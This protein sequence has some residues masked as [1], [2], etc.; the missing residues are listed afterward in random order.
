MT[1]SELKYLIKI[2]EMYDGTAGIRLTAIAA[3]MNVTKVSVFKAAERLEQDGCIRRDEKNKVIVTQ[4]GR[5]QLAKYNMLIGWLGGHLE[6]NCKVPADI[7]RH[8]A[9]GAV[10][11]FSEE[12]IAALTEFITKQKEN[13]HDR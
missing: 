4:H 1:S 13:R 11:A 2:N 7:A 12:S 6:M 5:E 10:C 3:E 9:M 8:D